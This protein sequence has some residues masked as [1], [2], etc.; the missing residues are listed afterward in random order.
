MIVGTIL[1]AINQGNLILSAVALPPDLYWKIPLT[2]C[3]PFCVS[4]YAAV[5]A[6]LSRSLDR[7]E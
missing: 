3:V 5:D 4:T 2:Y 6:I 1:I 7:V